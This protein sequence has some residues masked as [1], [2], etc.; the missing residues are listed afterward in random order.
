MTIRLQITALG[1]VPAADCVASP[2]RAVALSKPTREKMQATTASAHARARRRPCSFSWVVSTLK[3]CLNR[4]MQARARMQA[5]EA[6]SR[7]R[8]RMEEIRMSLK[9]MNQHD[10]SR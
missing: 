1:H 8:V 10:A 2:P 3:P 7:T 9:A 4:T 5:T 6:A